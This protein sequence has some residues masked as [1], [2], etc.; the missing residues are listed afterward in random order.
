MTTGLT[1]FK[2]IISTAAFRI[3]QM[4]KTIHFLKVRTNM[5]PPPTFSLFAFVQTQMFEAFS[6]LDRTLRI[7]KSRERRGA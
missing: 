3:T 2:N 6:I 4:Q 1:L 7:E 5:D